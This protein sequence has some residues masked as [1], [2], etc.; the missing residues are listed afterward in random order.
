M[1]DETEEQL[2][3]TEEERCRFHEASDHLKKLRYRTYC[4]VL[5]LTGCRESEPLF[6][7][8]KHLNP[9]KKSLRMRTLKRRKRKVIFRPIPI[10]KCL[11]EDLLEHID[12]YKTGPDERLWPFCRTTA[13]SK[14]KDCMA[15]AGITGNQ[16]MPKGLRHGY[17][18]SAVEYKLSM[19]N[20]Q[21]NMGHKNPESTLS[22]LNFVGQDAR[23]QT[24]PLW[25]ITV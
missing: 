1:Y 2:Y 20:L 25:N 15:L 24:R 21:K 14:V 18:T 17:A 11:V 5:V 4:K 9:E 19:R 22:Y 10:P 3:L 13:W 16:A 8:A 23:D 12:Y 6:S 7:L